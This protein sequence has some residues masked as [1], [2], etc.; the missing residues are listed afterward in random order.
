MIKRVILGMLVLSALVGCE[1]YVPSEA[2]CFE[3]QSFNPEDRCKFTRI[4]G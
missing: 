4:A 1:P 3:K 2:N